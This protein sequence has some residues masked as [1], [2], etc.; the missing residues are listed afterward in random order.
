MD[1]RKCPLCHRAHEV[2]DDGTIPTWRVIC[3]VDDPLLKC[4]S[5]FIHLEDA[6]EEYNGIKQKLQDAMKWH[7]NK[8]KLRIVEE[9]T[10]WDELFGEPGIGHWE[11]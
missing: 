5:G 9:R 11:A 1:E 10:P 6:Q 8:A 2:A 4:D 3:E 7:R